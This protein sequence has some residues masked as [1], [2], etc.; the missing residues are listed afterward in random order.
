MTI[1]TQQIPVSVG[2]LG[3]RTDR[4]IPMEPRRHTAAAPPP[5]SPDDTASKSTQPDDPSTSGG[6][7]A[8]S[9][10]EFPMQELSIRKDPEI[11]RV[12][13]QVLDSRT[14]EVV[15]QIPS[16]EWVHVLKRL[17]GAKGLLVDRKG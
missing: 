3:T 12:I 9:V 6:K 4:P 17:K 2:E 7:A 1:N 14:G 5:G 16:E 13:V 8:P 11:D 15:R 10:P